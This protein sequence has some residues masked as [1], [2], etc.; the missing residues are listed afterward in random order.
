MSERIILRDAKG[1]RGRGKL[2][3]NYGKVIKQDMMQLQLIDYIPF[4]GDCGDL[5]LVWM[6]ETMI[7][8]KF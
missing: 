8:G 7:V 1:G 5:G 2:K 3:K 6:T 4:I